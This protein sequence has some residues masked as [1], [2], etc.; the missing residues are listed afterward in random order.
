MYSLK[1]I[2]VLGLLI[3]STCLSGHANATSIV[4]NGET[5]INK[6]TTF[7]NVTL[8]L[9]HGYFT[10]ANN[11]ILDIEN[12][13]I[14]GIISPENPFFIQVATGKLILINNTVRVRVIN[15]QPSPDTTSVFRVINVSRGTVNIVG[16]R[17]SVDKAFTVG[18]FVTEKYPT[19]HFVIKANVIEGFHGG[20][21]LSNSRNAIIAGNQF[22]KVSVTN[23]LAIGSGDSLF[24]RNMILLAGNNNVGNGIDIIYS[25]N[26]IV[27]ENYIAFGSCYSIYILRSQNVLVDHNQILGGVT[28][29]I[30]IV[31]LVDNNLYDKHLGKLIGE[32]KSKAIQ[33]AN[34]NISVTNNVFLQNRF[35][36]A[37][38]EVDGLIVKNNMFIQKFPDNQTRRFWTNNDILFKN[39]TNIT[40]D[41]NR[42]REAFTQDILGNN[43]LAF[44]I[45]NFPLHGGVSL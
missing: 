17:F 9:S 8:D 44:K 42:Y 19:A 15:I 28:Y 43:E 38:T 23:I 6:P 41:D 14:K 34:N 24:E 37:A 27:S 25:D 45:V 33:Y 5:I 16:N 22:S 40:W 4:I 1:R 10:I 7:K 35:G 31:P 32:L 2:I 36:L 39:V 26:M 3:L 12:C 13:V 21:F 30:Y 29:A 11:S 18:L 20:F